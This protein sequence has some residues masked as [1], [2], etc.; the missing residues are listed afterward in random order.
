MRLNGG[1]FR[2]AVLVHGSHLHLVIGFRLQVLDGELGAAD[3]GMNHAIHLYLIVVGISC[4]FQV[5]TSS[6]ALL[7]LWLSFIVT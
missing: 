1:P 7:G 6:N 2:N 5:A 4:L 3:G